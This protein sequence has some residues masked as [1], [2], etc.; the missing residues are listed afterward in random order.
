VTKILV[1][2]DAQPLRKDIVEMLAFEGFDVVGAE[3]GI[4]GVQYALETNPDLIICDIMMPELDGYGVLERLRQEPSTRTTPF[5]F[6]TARTDRSDVR[7]GMDMGAE[8]YL[9]K[10]FAAS[11]LISTVR[12][13]LRKRAIYAQMSEQK[14]DELRENIILS[15]PHEL[16][17]PLTSILGFSDILM[18][19]A[20]TLEP[21]RIVELSQYINSAALRLYRLIE[22]Y[23]FYAQL[24]LLLN[25]P[26][27][28]EVMRRN[29]TSDPAVIIQDQAYI[30]AQN[31]GREMDLRMDGLET[32]TL[33][34]GDE[35]LKKIVE[36][37]ADNA[38]KFS[39]VGQP[40]YIGGR[41]NGDTYV[42][43]VTDHGRGMTSQQIADVG[44]YM[45]FD[46]R[47]HEQQGSGLGLI[48]SKRL[49]ELHG[50]WMTIESAPHQQTTICV[51]LPL[52]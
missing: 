35:Y 27:R 36:E 11:E 52:A 13:Q 3:N 29:L 49:A 7:Q 42:L 46:R 16:R 51:A 38:F 45:Q 19:D 32:A 25:D 4:Q 10:P 17:T 14:L 39:E 9:T 31:V 6:L 21:Q 1:I 40:V 12:A 34:M 22:N 2:E 30:S 24:E 18:V 44:A 47:I 48:I 50:G 37:L 41:V 5:V 20:Y 23:L 33:G 43:S 8:D 28:I 26:A 15:L